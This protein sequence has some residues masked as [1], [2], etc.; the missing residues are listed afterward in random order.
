MGNICEICYSFQ[1][2][3]SDSEINRSRNIGGKNHLL[4]CRDFFNSIIEISNSDG[5]SN[6]QEKQRQRGTVETAK[7]KVSAQ[8]SNNK[9]IK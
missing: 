7:I 5:S 4:I 3:L 9:Y 1:D 2:V 8:I 6:S